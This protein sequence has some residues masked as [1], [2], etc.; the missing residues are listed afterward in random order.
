M[1]IEARITGVSI[2]NTK[3]HLTFPG[4]SGSWIEISPEDASGYRNLANRGA[5]CVIE[6]REK[7][8]RVQFPA[9]EDN[10]PVSEDVPE[11]DDIP[12]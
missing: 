6:I 11:D 1:K 8:E 2:N 5:E 9:Y 12:F 3:I 7:M 10:G 4:G